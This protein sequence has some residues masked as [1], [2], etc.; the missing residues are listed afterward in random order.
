MQHDNDSIDM[1][2]LDVTRQGTPHQRRLAEVYMAALQAR[3]ACT[4]GV[5]LRLRALVGR[6]IAGAHEDAA[7]ALVGASSCWTSAASSSAQPAWQQQLLLLR[8]LRHDHV[9]Q[10]QQRR[11]SGRERWRAVRGAAANV[12]GGPPALRG[13]TAAAWA[14]APLSRPTKFFKFR[15]RGRRR[16]LLLPR[17]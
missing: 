4:R 8:L 1:L 12:G 7:V 13:T 5:R 10:Q 6:L 15:P 14:C 11:R 16:A 17:D 3:C 9:E 2:A